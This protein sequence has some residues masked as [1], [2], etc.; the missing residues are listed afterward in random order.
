MR[1]VELVAEAVAVAELV[2]DAVLVTLWVS[3]P[4]AVAVAVIEAVAEDVLVLVPLRVV[5]GVD[6]AEHATQSVIPVPQGHARGLEGV[7][8]AQVELEAGPHVSVLGPPIP[9]LPVYGYALRKREAESGTSSG[10]H[11]RT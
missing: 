4:V 8:P 2:P 6:D 10:R 9:L 11:L 7:P 3:E 5:D 1:P